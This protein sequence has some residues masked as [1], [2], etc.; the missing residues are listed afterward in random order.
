MS[1]IIPFSQSDSFRDSVATIER[2][3]VVF[4]RDFAF[5]IQPGERAIFSPAI[6]SSSKNAS[7]DPRT[8]TLGGTTLQGPD[9]E[10]L[11]CL[12]ARFSASAKTFIE[13]AFPSY[14]T[15]LER[16]RASFRPAE[17]AG[18]RSSWRKDD[19]RLHVD[20][21]PATPVNGKRILRL[22]TNVNPAGRARVWRVGG[23]F[24]STA[25]RFSGAL[26]IPPP[27]TAL[28]LRAF[29]VTKAR[30]SD[31]DALMLQLHDRMKQDADFQSH[32]PQTTFDFPAGSTWACFT[33]QVGHAAMSG[34]YQLEQTFYLPVSAM[35]DESRSPLRVLERLKGRRLL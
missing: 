20:A 1:S 4:V 30:R 34:Q 14:A 15:S 31:Y 35:K 7:F 5:E 3:D 23:D 32:A 8:G 16:A 10:A 2:G 26:R 29:R 21:F 24:E 18:R 9:A 12:M 11:R 27:G 33:D 22:F 6:L 25:A 19:T 28:L 13:R 17:I